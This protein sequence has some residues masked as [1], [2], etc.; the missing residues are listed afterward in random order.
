MFFFV[1]KREGTDVLETKIKVSK[2]QK[3][4]GRNYKFSKTHQTTKVKFYDYNPYEDVKNLLIKVPI[5]KIMSN[6]YSL[7]Y[8]EY[9]KDETEEEQ[10]EE[11]VV[12]K[13][14]G[15]VCSIDYGTRIVR[16]NNIEGEYP[17]Y[18]SGRAMFSTE[19]FN[20]E[21]FNILIGRFALSLECVRFVNE[22]IFLNDSGLSVKSKTD[23]LL[24]KYVG[25]YLLHNQNIIYNCAR[26]TAQKNLEMDIFK[27]IK[28]PIPSLDKQQEIVK[29]LDFIY[30]K[31]NKTSNDKITELKQ[32]NEFC[33]NNQK[34]FGENENKKLGE[35]CEFIKTGKNK[36]TDNKTGTLYPYYGTGSITGYTDEYLY[37]GYYILTARNGTIGNCFL[38]EGKFFPSDHIFVID[39]KDKCLM[40]Y[41]YYILSNNEK[42]DK[43]KTGVGIPNITKGTLENL[44]IPVPLLERQKEIVEYCEY[45]DTLIKQLEKEIENN[46]KQTQQFITGIV[47]TQVKEDVE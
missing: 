23:I 14:L 46:K 13:T 43:L 41:V 9:M 37:D 32:L 20:R 30:E 18:G 40:K 34:I 45:N 19:T 6:S 21:G 15:E 22:K 47:K 38:T 27:S 5:D 44:I 7:N 11:G 12:V 4:T 3:E 17:V 8:A 35:L 2:T 24:H 39:I 42:L 31:A 28:I 26:G 29:Y 1:K 36:P 25:Y 10:Y 16:K 33:L